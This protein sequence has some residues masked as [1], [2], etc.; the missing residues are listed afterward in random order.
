MYEPGSLL[1]AYVYTRCKVLTCHYFEYYVCISY[2]YLILLCT[3]N[4]VLAVLIV[5]Y[6]F[7][8]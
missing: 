6:I 8:T 1:Q 2:Q 7:G 5:A 4:L 3:W